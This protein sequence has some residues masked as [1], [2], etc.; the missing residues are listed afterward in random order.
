MASNIKNFKCLIHFN[1]TQR[2]SIL[3]EDL[4]YSMSHEMVMQK[5]NLE[6]NAVINLSFKLSSFDF[7]VDITD[8]SEVKEKQEKDKIGSKPDRNGKRGK[9]RQCRR[10]ITVEKEEKKKKIQS[11]RDKRCKFP[12]LY[13]RKIKD[14]G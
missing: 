1:E 9:A 10:P 14:K 8:D 13:A 6:A 12:K 5:F 7:V 11:S 2:S 4:T 3:S